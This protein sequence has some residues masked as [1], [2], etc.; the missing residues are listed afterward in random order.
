MKDGFI[1]YK[2]MYEPI[3]SYSN[4]EKGELLDAIFQYQISGAISDT[5]SDKVKIAFEFFRVQ[6]DLDF[7]KYSAKCAKNKEVAEKRW[8]NTNECERIRTNANDTDKDKEKDKD[9]DKEKEKE[10]V[11]E[12]EKVDIDFARMLQYWNDHCGNMPKI[13]KLSD[14]RKA[15]I[16]ARYKEHGKD[17]ILKAIQKSETSDFMQGKKTDFVG[18]FD[19]MI[20]AENFVKIL[21]GNYDNKNANGKSD[22]I[23]SQI[24]RTCY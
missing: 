3:R 1:L 2:K 24:N 15:A 4:A 20:K 10:N 5:L 17:G 16:T 9:K 18:S 13:I 14:K 22:W 12:K 19:F 23:D 11:K 6:M 8:K 7:D 21:E